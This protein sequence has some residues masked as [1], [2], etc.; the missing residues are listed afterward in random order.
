[1]LRYGVVGT[2]AVGGFYGIRLAHAGA[3]VQFLLRGGALDRAAH[4]LSLTSPEGDLHLSTVNEAARWDELEPCDVLIVA[5]KATANPDV[6]DHLARHA[7]RLIAPGGAVLLI[8]NGIG[9]E[10]AYARAA[11]GRDVLGGLA[12]L[13]ANRIDRRT[14][15]HV[16]FGTLTIARHAPAEVPGG[17]TPLMVAIAADLAVSGTGAALDDDL[18]RARWRKLMWNVPFNPLSVILDATTDLLMADPDVVAL[19]GTL[20][21]EVM[22]AATAEGRALPESLPEDLLAATAAMTPYATSMKLD[23][24][25]GRPM[26]VEAMLAEPLRRAARRGVPMPSVAVLYRQLA[27]LDARRRS[28]RA[29]LAS[30]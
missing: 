24:D 1:M 19:I 11:P 21:S 22:A 2:G 13:C 29:S 5:A 28:S 26:E 6:L 16:D 23:A 3:R 25:A 27:F 15:A 12:F 8:Q 30:P 14:I 9:A 7:Q 18:V 10:P 20:M 17:V 4:G